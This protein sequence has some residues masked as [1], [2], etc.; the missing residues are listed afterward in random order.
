MGNVFNNTG[1]IECCYKIKYKCVPDVVLQLVQ[2]EA[3]MKDMRGC[4]C[5]TIVQSK[6][7]VQGRRSQ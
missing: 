1:G 2:D 7:N 4:C 3:Q 6:I 5:T